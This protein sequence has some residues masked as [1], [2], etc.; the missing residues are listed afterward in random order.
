M[1]HFIVQRIYTKKM[2]IDLK[3]ILHVILEGKKVYKTSYN[4]NNYY[5][6]AKNKENAQA[7][8]SGH[9]IKRVWI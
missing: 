4:G 9:I 7:T 6:L 8:Y 3:G 1:I 5:F 2:K